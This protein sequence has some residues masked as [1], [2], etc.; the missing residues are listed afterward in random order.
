MAIRLITFLATNRFATRSTLPITRRPSASTD[1]MCENLPSSSTSW[2]TALVACAPLPI[3]TPM[4]ASFRASASLTPSPVI[5]TT[6]PLR[7][8]ACTSARFCSGDTRPKTMVFSAIS[9][10]SS[11]SS[12]RVR[13]STTDV[14][15]ELETDP[16]GDGADGGRVVAGDDLDP[17]ALVLEVLQR[18]LRVRANLLGQRHQRHRTAPRTGV[19]GPPAARRS[20]RAAAPDGRS[21]PARSPARAAG[22]RR[23]AA[24][25]ARRRSAIRDR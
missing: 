6:C 25:R 22:R 24:R 13:A 8:N 20:G 17:D 9:R 21:R 18:V 10:S 11:G 15:T 12:P 5:A 4:S 3:A 19:P 2:A 7:C 16:A 1:G 14:R 23:P